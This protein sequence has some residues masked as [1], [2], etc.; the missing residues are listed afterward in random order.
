M[1]GAIWSRQASAEGKQPSVLSTTPSTSTNNS[2]LFEGRFT[3]ENMHATPEE[4]GNAIA[5][6]REV[7]PK[8]T[9]L[10]CPKPFG[11][12]VVSSWRR[13][14]IVFI[15]GTVTGMVLFVCSTLA[16]SMQKTEVVP[17]GCPMESMSTD[18]SSG[19]LLP[20][21]SA[22]SHDPA[23][24]Y[25]F[26]QMAYDIPGVRSNQVWKVMA[27]ARTLMRFSDYPL[28][29][30]TNSTHLP[31]GVPLGQALERLNAQVLPLQDMTASAELGPLHRFAVLKL[32]IWLLTQYEKLVWLDTDAILVRSMDWLFE[33]QPLWGQR[34]DPSCQFREQTKEDE[35]LSSSILLIAPS[36]ETFDGLK[37]FA[38]KGPQDWWENDG[39]ALIQQYFH[40]EKHPVRLLDGMDAADGIC[41][42]RTPGVPYSSPGPW[43]LPAFVHRSSWRNECF[44]FDVGRQQVKRHGKIVNIC[45]FH[46]LGSYWRD[47]FCDALRITKTGTNNT[48]TFC[49]DYYWH[50]KD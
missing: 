37:R 10:Q 4:G 23:G 44:D 15:L 14:L 5:E 39:Q 36:K 29:V 30:L 17:H 16:S 34:D 42:G 40:R 26:V 31:D 24:R 43:N 33:R 22:G 21:A 9:C 45:H 3:N 32:Q 7:L 19:I 18:N 13:D 46:P 27:M 38:E 1:L 50:N 11:T 35:V 41:L 28:V 20:N 2:V 12:Y 8:W 6:S 49:D 47:M 25:A 48:D